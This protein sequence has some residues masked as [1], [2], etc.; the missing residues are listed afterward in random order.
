[1]LSQRKNSPQHPWVDI[2]LA[3]TQE[4]HGSMT[5]GPSAPT[6]HPLFTTRQTPKWPWLLLIS[7]KPCRIAWGL[8]TS[9]AEILGPGYPPLLSLWP[10]H[11][12][13]RVQCHICPKGGS[14]STQHVLQPKSPNFKTPHSEEQISYK[15]YQFY[16]VKVHILSLLMSDSYTARPW[17]RNVIILRMCAQTV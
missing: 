17:G 2:Q 8:K 12:R 13:V 5:G 16:N 9:L 4:V 3:A 6:E 7:K 15:L 10:W 1:M 11:L 14:T